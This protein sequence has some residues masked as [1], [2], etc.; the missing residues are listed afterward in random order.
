MANF[1]QAIVNPYYF[2]IFIS[3][4]SVDITIEP[5]QTPPLLKM[6]SSLNIILVSE[7]QPPA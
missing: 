1:S 7:I 5:H 2:A 4:Q 3:A 6:M